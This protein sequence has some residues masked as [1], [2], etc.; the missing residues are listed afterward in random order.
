M[1][2]SDADTISYV[3]V[4]RGM[5]DQT[6]AKF[7][8][9]FP[10]HRGGV[11]PRLRETYHTVQCELPDI[12]EDLEWIMENLSKKYTS[13]SL[14]IN[15]DTPRNWSNYDVPIEILIAAQKHAVGL[16]VSFS[17]PPTKQL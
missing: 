7:S 4:V 5:P 2:N 11:N 1:A 13:I 10:Q 9:R 15:I 17:S 8:E 12:C 3:I 14:G 6:H 16:R